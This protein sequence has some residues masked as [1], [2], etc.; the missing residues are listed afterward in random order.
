MNPNEVSEWTA[1]L[2]RD[3]QRA[4]WHAR[5]QT[6]RSRRM[7]AEAA[8]Q[9]N[10]A[11]DR[12]LLCVDPSAALEQLGESGDVDELLEVEIDRKASLSLVSETIE[13]DEPSDRG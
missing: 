13:P 8:E 3:A 5:G 11:V 7:R 1:R 12:L 10:E 9:V 4:R 6:Q 2:R